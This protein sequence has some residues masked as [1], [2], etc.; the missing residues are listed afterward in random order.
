MSI[1]RSTSTD[2]DPS[3]KAVDDA[4]AFIAT[5][6][7]EIEAAKPEPATPPPPPPP[8]APPPPP[9]HPPAPSDAGLD[10]SG[11]AAS[12]NAALLIG[13]GSATIAGGGALVHGGRS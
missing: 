13:A 10:A 8:P 5:L 2:A 9:P 4:K 7:Q 12:R 11:A 6:R 1:A 3:G